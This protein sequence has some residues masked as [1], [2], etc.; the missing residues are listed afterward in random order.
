MLISKISLASNRMGDFKRLLT[1]HNLSRTGPFVREAAR[2][3][4]LE[5]ERLEEAIVRLV[6][7][8]VLR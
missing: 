7:E 8:V 2:V 4:F 1:F 3:S 5:T 6:D